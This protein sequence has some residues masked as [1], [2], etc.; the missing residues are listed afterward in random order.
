MCRRIQYVQK[1]VALALTVRIRLTVLIVS[2]SYALMAV[3]INQEA[4]A[5]E[6]DRPTWAFTLENDVFA[7]TDRHYTSGLLVA[8]TLP[9]SGTPQWVSKL[10]QSTKLYPEKSRFQLSYTVG[11]KLYTPED[12]SKRV[13]TSNDRPYA[14]W[15][16][17]GVGLIGSNNTRHH[18]FDASIGVVGPS[19]LGD[20]SQ[21]W[22]HELTQ[23]DKP[24]G[25]HLQQTDEWT[26]Q[27]TYQ[28]RWRALNIILETLDVA[29]VPHFGGSLG[30]MQSYINVGGSLLLGQSLGQDFGPQRISPAIPGSATIG[31]N[32]SGWYL[33][34]SGELRWVNHDDLL[35]GSAQAS[36][37]VAEKHFNVD[38]QAGLTSSLGDWKLSYTVVHRNDEFEGQTGGHLFGSISVSRAH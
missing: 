22:I 8:Y 37:G 30:N 13:P 32:G 4:E 26:L 2:V 3:S 25:W 20:E 27:L 6:Y 1:Y 28:R 34:F 10:A 24:Q 33:F 18:S 9:D 16:F 35:D 19:A 36:E 23:S 5:Q 14:G 21:S 11:Q 12:I 29:F 15:L 31:L 17:A 7:K 38:L